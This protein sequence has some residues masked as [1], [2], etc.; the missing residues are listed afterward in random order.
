MISDDAILQAYREMMAV[1]R[2]SRALGVSEKRVCEVV[3][4]IVAEI[5]AITRA[6]VSRRTNGEAQEDITR[7]LMQQQWRCQ[8][9]G[10]LAQGEACVNGH[11]PPWDRRQPLRDP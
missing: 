11:P 8:E 7:E 4:P 10:A 5:R 9:C 2:V 6:R 1:R 3:A